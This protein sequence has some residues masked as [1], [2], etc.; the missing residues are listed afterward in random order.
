MRNGLVVSQDTAQTSLMSALNLFVGRG[1]RYSVEDVA[2]ASGVCARTID[3]YRRGDAMPSIE[4]YQ[5]LCAVLGQ[6][7]FAATVK[8]MPFEVRSTDPSDITPPQLL[9]ELLSASGSLATFL[10]DGRVDHM[11]K[12]QLK[13][14]LADLRERITAMENS[15]AGVST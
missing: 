2:E 14:I 10:E 12:A 6:A 4:R 15:L 11:E 5:S 3:S 1:K 13:P 9:T 8:H 7:F